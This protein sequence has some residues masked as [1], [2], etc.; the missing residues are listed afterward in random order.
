MG[1]KPCRWDVLLLRILRMK[2]K[3][4]GGPEAGPLEDDL[5][6]WASLVSPSAQR[7]RSL[8]PASSASLQP[9]VL[10]T[11]HFPNGHRVRRLS[12]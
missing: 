2:S 5:R 4:A 3:L 8:D 1:Q 12:A 10:K 11:G 6:L 9:A 7:A